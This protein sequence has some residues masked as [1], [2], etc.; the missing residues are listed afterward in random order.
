VNTNTGYKQ[1]FKNLPHF[2]L[3]KIDS[4]NAVSVLLHLWLHSHGL[5]RLFSQF[6]LAVITGK[7]QQKN[8][9]KVTRV[10]A[11]LLIDHL[12]CSKV[13]KNLSRISACNLLSKMIKCFFSSNVKR[14]I[15]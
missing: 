9:G 1:I 5:R 7:E 3:S 2:S 4:W 12:D 14:S 13:V 11:R 15:T 8:K 10:W 6:Q